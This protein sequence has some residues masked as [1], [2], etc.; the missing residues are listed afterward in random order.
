[1][2]EWYQASNEE[3]ISTCH[4]FHSLWADRAVRNLILWTG[5]LLFWLFWRVLH[6]QRPLLISQTLWCRERSTWDKMKRIKKFY[7]YFIFFIHCS[8]HGTQKK[9][10][11]CLLEQMMVKSVSTKSSQTSKIHYLKLFFFYNGLNLW[12]ESFKLHT[13]WSSL[14][15]FR[16]LC[17]S[18]CRHSVEAGWMNDRTHTFNYA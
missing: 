6:Y 2:A 10:A 9:K 4:L 11:P 7:F 14:T 13:H 12:F 18:R 5:L 15:S 8:W 3:P 17:L 16:M 1:M